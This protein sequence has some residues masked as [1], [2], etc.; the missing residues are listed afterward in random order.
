ME[1]NMPPIKDEIGKIKKESFAEI[2]VLHNTVDSAIKTES[3]ACTNGIWD[4]PFTR[5]KDEQS[6]E[7]LE[8]C[9]LNFDTKEHIKMEN[10]AAVDVEVQESEMDSLKLD[11]RTEELYKY[12]KPDIENVEKSD[13]VKE[14]QSTEDREKYELTCDTKEHINI[15]DMSAVDV[16]IEVQE[17]EIDSL[18]QDML[19]EEIDIKPD[20]GDDA[21]SYGGA[22]QT[23]SEDK[24]GVVYRKSDEDTFVCYICNFI[25]HSKKDLI[26]HI[27]VSGCSVKSRAEKALTKHP[28]T[29]YHSKKWPCIHCNATFKS[30]Q[31]LDGHV[32]KNHGEFISSVSSK[33]HQCEHCSYKTTILSHLTRHLKNL[34]P[35]S[36]RSIVS[37]QYPCIYCDATF[38]RKTH[39]D[40]HVLRNHEEFITAVSFK[41]WHCIHCNA[42]FKSKQALNGH[43]IKNHEEFI[44]SVSSPIHQCKHCSYKTTK[45]TNL[46]RHLTNVHADSECSVTP[47]QYGCNHCHAIFKAKES[48]DG[49]ILRNHEEF[50]T[51]VSSK[52]HRCKHCS[53]K[54]TLSSHMTRHLTNCHPESCCSVRSKQYPCNHCH[55]IFKSKAALDDHIIR[56]HE[57]FISS[58]SSKIHQCKHCSY[59]TTTITNLTRHLSKHPESGCSFT[60]K[61]YPCNHCHAIFKRKVA[62]DDHIIRNHEEFITSISSKIYDCKHCSYKTTIASNVTRH[63][64]KHPE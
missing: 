21:E 48:L 62:L 61:Q 59:K 32:I 8:Q 34:H 36:W 49:H 15:E 13:G 37:I 60:P 57:E 42:G 64:T 40:D 6:M 25:V 46:S 2:D 30:K 7:N 51:S 44:T 3:Y 58:V 14:E 54:T 47:N 29:L 11:I 23:L 26:N 63:L 45:S 22:K 18:K 27:N 56:N 33:I 17:S 4:L 31:S 5:V 1:D 19:T 28:N 16:K 20:I 10:I 39:I 38:K 35:E 24:H 41:K 52:I 55:A 12:I 53:Y 43:V 9:E 50:I